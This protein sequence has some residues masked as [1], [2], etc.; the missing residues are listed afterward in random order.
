MLKE[1]P[2]ASTIITDSSCF[3]LLDK[4]ECLN[5][6]EELYGYIVTTP[7]I[8][9]EY[10]KRL[11]KWV[12]V[13]A[14][15]NRDLLYTYA[16]MIDIGASAIALAAEV[17]SPSLILDDLK[18]RKLAERLQLPY[19]GTIGVLVLA[20]TQGVIPLLQPYFEKIEATDFR[21]PV[22]FLQILLDKY[23]K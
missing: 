6:L 2:G 11:P 3:I 17:V 12:H 23:D 15:I 21:I 16:E 14:V 10:G 22:S 9:A 20:K 19:T 18:G 7:E 8:A 5:I 1:S 13:Q 4:I